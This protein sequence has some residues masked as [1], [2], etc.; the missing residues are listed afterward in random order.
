MGGWMAP[1]LPPPLFGFDFD[2]L[3]LKWF[4]FISLIVLFI[5]IVYEVL[6]VIF[7]ILFSKGKM[8]LPKHLP[9]FIYNWLNLIK[10]LSTIENKRNYIEAASLVLKHLIIYIL[11]FFV[12]LILYYIT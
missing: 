3:I 7:F 5:V 11:L 4:Y 1:P 9:S 2:P 8:K 6:D 10:T 12:F